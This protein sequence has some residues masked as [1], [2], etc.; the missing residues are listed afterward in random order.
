[1]KRP[2]TCAKVTGRKRELLCDDTKPC[3]NGTL[4]LQHD[5]ATKLLPKLCSRWRCQTCGPRKARRLRTRLER[6]APTRLITLTLRADP[7][8]TPEAM[9]RKANRAWSIL[10]RRYRRQFGDQALGYAKIVELTKAGTPHLHIIANVPYVHHA[11]LSA[12]WRELTGSYIVDIRKVRQRKGIAGYLSSYLTKALD[13]PPGMRKW[14]SSKGFVPPEAPR[15]LEDGEL[16]PCVKYSPVS[17]DFIAASYV[18][19]GYTARNGWLFPPEAEKTWSLR[20]SD[21]CGGLK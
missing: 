10:W 3:P 9:L 5:L 13:V 7:R 21:A 11:A 14:S 17:A 19:A 6:T 15:E 2:A 12:A 20:S 16:A 1:M 4:I 8:A 18:Q